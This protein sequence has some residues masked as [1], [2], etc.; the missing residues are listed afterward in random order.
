MAVTTEQIKLLREQTNAGFMDCKNVLVKTNGN[1]DEAVAELRKKGLAVAAKRADKAA[2][3]GIIESYIHLGGKI[4]V[5]VEINCETDF[6][7]RNAQFQQFVK[8]VAMHIAAASPQFLNKEDVPQA[9]L[10]KEKEI[11]SSQA[12][13]KPAN[14]VEKMLEGKINKFYQEVCLLEQTFVKD[15]KL[16]IKDYLNSIIAKIGENIRIRRFARYQIGEEI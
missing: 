12:G 1:I 14:V 10:D 6:V 3:E 11:I 4:G 9:L 2:K 8:D 13:D 16:K 15:D 7:A 5:L